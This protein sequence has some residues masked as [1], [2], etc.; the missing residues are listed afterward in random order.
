MRRL[1][2]MAEAPSSRPYR[3]LDAAERDADRRRRLLDSALELFGTKGY[4]ATTL[5][6]VCSEARVTARNFYDHFSS[7]EELLLALYDEVTSAHLAAVA[8]AMSEQP[9]D[10]MERVRAGV[11]AAVRNWTAD[12]RRARVAQLEILGRSPVAERRRLETIGLYQ[13]LVLSTAKELERTG[14]LR[15]RRWEI[16]S[17]A[18]VGAINEAIMDWTLRA[19]DARPLVDDLVD[20]LQSLFLAVLR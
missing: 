4:A 6:E 16:V 15:P 2:K 12:E 10:A 3:G 9:D 11:E 5:R 13:Q 17:V 20:E 1:S 19:P 8:A 14:A 18:L 7:R